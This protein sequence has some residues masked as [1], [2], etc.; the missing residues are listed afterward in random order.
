MNL[1]EFSIT[2]KEYQEFQVEYTM[3]VLK[4]PTYRFG[5]AFLCYFPDAMAYLRS[6][7]HLGG[8]PGHARYLDDILWDEKSYKISKSMIEDYIEII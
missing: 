1:P 3:T 2:E 5:Q 4:V 7:S 8:N 6:N